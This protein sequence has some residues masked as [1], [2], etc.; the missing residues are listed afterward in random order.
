VPQV[1]HIPPTEAELECW[2]NNTPRWEEYT[3][4]VLRL[5]REIRRLRAL[6]GEAAFTIRGDF[7]GT[8]ERLSKAAKGGI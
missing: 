1:D 7:P 5:V 4:L 2:E 8:A 6:C 3:T